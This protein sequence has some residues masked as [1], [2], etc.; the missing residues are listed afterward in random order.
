MRIYFVSN[1]F[2]YGHVSRDVELA[3]A[4]RE[5]GHEVIFSTY[6]D[7]LVFLRNY[8][9]EVIEVEEFGEVSF[10]STE[11]EVFKTVLNT[12]RS[13]K[14][15]MLLEAR[16]I[17]R[18][19]SPDVMVVD[20]YVPAMVSKILRSWR[21][22]RIFLITNET[23]QWKKL[24][25]NLSLPIKKLGEVAEAA[26]VYLADEIIVPDFPPPYTVCLEN[27][28]FY[29]QKRK[30]H[31]VG[32]M[33]PEL[34]SRGEGKVVV[35]FGGSGVNPDV[36]EALSKAEEI[37]GE[38]FIVAKGMRR[39]R[40]LE[41]LSRARVLI[42][43][44]GHNSIMEAIACAKPIVGIPIKNYPEREGNLRGVERLG[45][46]RM[47]DAEWITGDSLATAIQEV[48]LPEFRRRLDIFSALA[49]R[50]NGVA[51]AVEIIENGTH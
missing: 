3:K 44:G 8:D 36:T 25:G 27:L 38:S 6:G 10:T 51:K 48:S 31:F 32:P 19:V 16:R 14:P 9:F 37:L 23:I 46:G 35:N 33:L 29:D 43:H 30:F 28:A 11:I 13:V 40:Y 45:V 47:L 12:L 34:E 24:E 26:L 20:G 22:M 39:E 15:G 1:G 18:D 5:R 42:T 49:R 41:H 21:K 4:L 7:G 50:T 2:G 17:L